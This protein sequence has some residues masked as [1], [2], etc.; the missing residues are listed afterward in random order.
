M[1]VQCPKC[2]A[3][4]RIPDDRIPEGGGSVKVRCKNCGH[5]MDVK[6]VD[7]SGPQ[8]QE[9][10]W[11]VA[12]GNDKRGPLGLEAVLA[13]IRSGE[14]GMETYVWRKGFKEWVR[15]GDVP[16][17]SREVSGTRATRAA[18]QTA[19]RAMF[20]VEGSSSQ[21]LEPT[22]ME[23]LPRAMS[24]APVHE[25]PSESSGVTPQPVLSPEG[26]PQDSGAYPSTTPASSSGSQAQ[27]EESETRMIWQRRETSVLFSLDDYKSRRKT[28]SIKP[29]AQPV[30]V[31][32]P[33]EVSVG[34]EEGPAPKGTERVKVISLEE[35]EVRRVADALSRR[36]RRRAM[37]R[38][39]ALALVGVVVVGIGV[40]IGVT[41][42]GDQG[43][44]PVQEQAVAPAAPAPAPP[45]A[46]P[47]PP[48]ATAPPPPPSPP[49]QAVVPEPPAAPEPKR[50]DGSSTSKT[51]PKAKPV[52]GEA[53]SPPPPPRERPPEAQPQPKPAT[54]DV[55]ALLAN[56]RSGQP[57]QGTGERER[58]AK[59][60]EEETAE[61]LPEQLTPGQ[62]QSV[63]RKQQKSVEDCIRKSGVAPG[64]TVTVNTRVEIEGSGRVS[65]VSVSNAGAAEGCI[66]SVL[67]GLKFPRF[68]GPNMAVPYPFRVS[69]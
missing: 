2:N 17:L 62:I 48:E 47:P 54:D 63:L 10:R 29:V 18:S 4:Y 24:E 64:T 23:P 50:T 61:A 27:D 60:G 49:P 55:N 38:N 26:A 9:A 67:G 19:T 43:S 35:A 1:K 5:V 46:P 68:K 33:K 65:S 8:A 31:V 25:R 52:R 45:V 58:A 13:L 40:F 69:L 16:E 11:F 56:L 3:T 20:S 22:V 39:G 30:P 41:R 28:R 34:P 42:I 51:T 66:R 7:A 32:Q 36:Q 12:V 44:V 53:S 59:P 57:S 14:I 21:D 37:I 15:L 6:G